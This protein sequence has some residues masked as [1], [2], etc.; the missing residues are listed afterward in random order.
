MIFLSFYFICV[1]YINYI[2]TSGAGTATLPEH[3]SSHPVFSGVSVA[4][5][6]VFC[7]VL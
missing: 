6:S 2:A 4:R 3:P 1:R 7:S 5:S